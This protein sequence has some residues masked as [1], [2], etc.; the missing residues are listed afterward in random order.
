MVPVVASAATFGAW[1]DLRPGLGRQPD[2]SYYAERL[3]EAELIEQ[4][5]LG[6]VWG[7]EHHG[8]T[9]GH[10]SQQLPF[11][12][13]VAAR[14]GSLRLGTGVLLLPLH[15]P[16]DVAEQAGEVDLVSG[17]R[18]LLG[19]GNG[20][21][22]HEFDAYGVDRS[23]R[24]RR[25]E[26]GVAYLRRAFSEGVAAD[27]PDGTDLPVGPRPAQPGGPPLLLGGMAPR[28]LERVA[29]I[30]DGW[31]CLAHYRYQKAADAWPVLREALEK[32]GRPVAGFPIVIG[33]HLWVSDDPERAW[34]TQ[35]APGLAFQLGRYNEWST[36]RGQPPPPP[37]DQ[38]RLKRSAVLC[39][40]PERVRTALAELQEQL[41][42]THVCL[43]SRP[44]GI[45]HEDACANLERVAAE[46]APA[47]AGPEPAWRASG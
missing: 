30:A 19:L 13:A 22:Q 34:A 36:D 44:A 35:L 26:E 2:A 11:L 40:T 38:Q 23:A 39:D 16:R 5:G 4:L 43:W 31:F 29:R 8:D 33:V 7:S 41:P 37:I 14:T 32:A 17:G 25:M 27:G 15:R 28:A 3:E 1:M 24:A 45:G 47:F 42:F 46:V 18:L 9:D 10:L 12:A 21:V 20:Y 6:A